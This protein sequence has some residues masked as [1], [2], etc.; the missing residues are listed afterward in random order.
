MHKTGSS[1]G[2][3]FRI[4]ELGFAGAAF[5]GAELV[6]EEEGREFWM[7]GFRIDLVWVVSESGPYYHA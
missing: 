4:H 1:F 7:A 2:D 5:S 6:D 3:D